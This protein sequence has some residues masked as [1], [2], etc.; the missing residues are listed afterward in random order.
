MPNMFKKILLI[1]LFLLILFTIKIEA[2]LIVNSKLVHQFDV[3]AGEKK[4][5]EIVLKNDTENEIMVRLY[6][7]DY[8][9]N[10]KGNTFYRKPGFNSRSNAEWI[11]LPE[12][13]LSIS[14]FAKERV[15]YIVN[16]P[17]KKL[18]G[19]YWCMVMVEEYDPQIKNGNKN[20]ENKFN[21]KVRYGIQMVTNLGQKEKVKIGHRNPK[22]K[23]ESEKEY[24]FDID[25]INK[26]IFELKMIPQIIVVNENT[27]EI[28]N[29]YKKKQVRLYP[30]TSI[31]VKEKI[32]LDKDISY[33]IIVIVGNNRRGYH[34]KE[35]S[36]GVVSD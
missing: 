12:R 25:I 29:K 34:G 2:G 32:S 33:K 6:K 13:S 23:K 17:D 22:V 1:S 21:H 26:G 4:L 10:A 19:T 28:M 8:S 24:I 20:I 15:Q 30:G 35:Y 11:L 36:I 3:G 5:G 14:P 27:G 7:R 18:K 31:A 9:F 16:I